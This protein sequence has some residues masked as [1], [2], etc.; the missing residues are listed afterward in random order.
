VQCYEQ[1][2][3]LWDENP[4]YYYHLAA[5]AWALLGDLEKALEYLWAAL[6]HVWTNFEWPVKQE[7][8]GILHDTPAWTT[9]RVRMNQRP[10]QG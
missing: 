9:I 6:D 8:F 1:V 2:F 10:M 3:A 7:E 4:D 5:S